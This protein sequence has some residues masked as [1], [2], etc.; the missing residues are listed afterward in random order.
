MTNAPH[1][2]LFSGIY[3]FG[4]FL[5]LPPAA[6]TGKNAPAEKQA[7]T[8]QPEAPLPSIVF[9]MVDALRADSLGVYGNTRGLTP[10]ID[11]VAARGVT[12][13][14]VIAQ[15]PWT[16]PSVAS[17][18][19]SRY[20]GVHGITEYRKGKRAKTVLL[21]DSF[22]TLAE[23]LHERGYATA[24]FVA[25]P[26]LRGKAGFAQGFEHFDAKFA[27]NTTPGSVIND[28]LIAWLKRRDPARPFFVYLHYM[29]VHGPYDAGPEFLDVLLEAVDRLPTRQ[30][31]TKEALDA[32]P[33]YL[34][35]TPQGRANAQRHKRLKKYRE[36]WVARY[37]AGV[38]ELDH[39]LADLRARLRK[40]GLWDQA[41][42]IITADHG[43]AL[44]EHHLWDHG[45]SA[46]HTDLHVPLILYQPGVL[47]AGKRVRDTVR[48]IDVMPTIL[49]QLHLPVP[50]GMQGVS[51]CA[52]LTGQP[53]KPVPALAEAVKSEPEQRALYL[54]DWKLM[55]FEDETCRLYDLAT[56]PLEQ[57]DLA[58]QNAQR[59]RV[60]LEMLD[61]Q[62]ELNARLA[63][64]VE[65]EHT[66]LTPEQ[67][68]RLRSLGYTN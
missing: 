6:T 53:L 57:R 50:P 25:N 20:P 1:C 63:E 16:Q 64:G 32:Q 61:E 45:H 34:R 23:S 24:A 7:T 37:E 17:L 26:W 10:S 11:A 5:G 56:D 62:V 51:L 31:L 29:D 60:L 43:E 42:V 67:L 44:C 27:K 15:A 30:R 14:R 28:A 66:P 9:M 22:Q 39:H 52:H 68:E 2:V 13:D 40:M 48:L 18:F 47:P 35:T 54:G 3:A 12:F 38:R 8:T 46:H 33:E 58:E 36:Y 55:T 4:A 21:D 65:L 59:V 41:Y 49:E 19:V